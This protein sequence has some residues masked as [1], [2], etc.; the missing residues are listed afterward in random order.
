M[1]KLKTSRLLI[2]QIKEKI[3]KNVT[4]KCKI[5]KIFEIQDFQNFWFTIRSR[6]AYYLFVVTSEVL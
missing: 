5:I 3:N 6:T 2:P 1:K 4:K